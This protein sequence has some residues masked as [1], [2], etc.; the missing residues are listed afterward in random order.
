MNL[1]KIAVLAGD[2]IGPEV[3]AQAVRVLKALEGPGLRFEFTEA[4]IG[5]VAH[6]KH[7]TS[8]P[9]ETFELAK[10]ADAILFGAVGGYQED[11][12][13]RGERPGDALL[14]LRSSLGLYANF[15]P[16]VMFPELIGA[17]TLKP[18]VVR[19][20][21]LIILRELVGGIYFGQPRGIEKN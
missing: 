10:R 7:G 5:A 15:R 12:F 14:H 6:R 2:G 3:V 18:E 4:A 13:S 9:D 17:S 11:A 8:L 20:L 21:D 16:V 19:G 1:M